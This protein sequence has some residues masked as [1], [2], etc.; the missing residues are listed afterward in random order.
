MLNGNGSV[1]TSAHRLLARGAGEPSTGG[2]EPQVVAV[3]VHRRRAG[4]RTS[5]VQPR[6]EKV[7]RYLRDQTDRD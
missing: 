6:D 7:D 5:A 1:D 3:I 4:L 2:F